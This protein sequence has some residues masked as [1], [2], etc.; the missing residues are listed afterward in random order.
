MAEKEFVTLELLMNKKLITSY[1]YIGLTN[2]T[3]DSK[4]TSVTFTNETF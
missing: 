1:R 2:V 4:L 3:G